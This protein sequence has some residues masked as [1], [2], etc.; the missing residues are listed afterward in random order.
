MNFKGLQRKTNEFLV[1]RYVERKQVAHMEESIVSC[2][3]ENIVLQVEFS[4]NPT[5]KMRNKI[6]SAH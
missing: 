2:D 1:H 3:G 6:Q 5:I 4:R